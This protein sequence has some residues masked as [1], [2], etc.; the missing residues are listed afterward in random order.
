LGILK[1]RDLPIPNDVKE[2]L[3]NDGY[4]RL[5]PPQ[6]ESINAGVLE[7]SNLVLASPTASGKTLIAELCIIKN[8][9]EKGGK[10]VYLTPLKALASEK[11]DEFLKYGDLRRDGN[12]LRIVISTGDFDRSDEWLRNYDIIISTN[13]KIDS[14]FRHGVT[15]IN[16]IKTIVADETHLITEP[17]RG[18]TLEVILTKLKKVNPNAQILLLSATIRN[19][20]EMAE[21]IKANPITMNWRP[22]PLKEGVFYNNNIEFNDGSIKEIKAK[23]EDPILDII[24]DTIYN[25]GQALTFTETRRTAVKQGKNSSK[26]V[27][28]LLTQREKSMLSEIAERI[29]STG[30][31]TILSEELASQIKKGTS[32][33]HAGLGIGHR[34]IIEESFRKRKIKAL[35]ATPT[36]AAGVNLPARVV[37]ISSYSRYEPG[38]GRGQI[39]VLEYKQFSGRAGRPK[40]D[41]FGESVLIAKTEDEKE[42]LIE[43]YVKAKPERIES[44][45]AIE[46][47]LRPHILSTI[48]S[49]FVYTKKGLYDFFGETFYAYQND[50]ETIHQKMKSILDFLTEAEMVEIAGNYLNA[51]NFGRRV[52]ELYIDP[53]SAVIIREALYNRAKVLTELSFLHLLS[54]T[55]DIAPKLY[56]R[57][58]EEKELSIFAQNHL[59]EFM[60]DTPNTFYDYE[61]SYNEFLSELKCAA[62]LLEWINEKSEDEILSKYKVEPGDLARLVQNSEW[63]LYATHELA[64]LFGHKD[65]LNILFELRIR[66]KNGVKQELVHLVQLE[67]VGRIRARM[68][69]NSGFKSIDS[70][71]SADI[72]SLSKVPLI[73]KSIA[74]KI[75]EQLGGKIKDSEL[76]LIKENNKSDEQSLLT[77]FKD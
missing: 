19:A 43:N 60:T 28:D 51:T 54:H 17:D 69:F 33:H 62:V 5:Y 29:L 26:A 57:S 76:K 55:P 14:L 39:S 75:K 66:V 68:L 35:A 73:G 67:R 16:E 70:L 15:W 41:D 52:S 45:L 50:S 6:V 3:F 20:E 24:S 12:K 42:F 71:K 64:K 4:D 22:V 63:L 36:L 27:S 40:Y 10:A 65:L 53:L 25:G 1:V 2:I 31:K 77:E 34:K 58:K 38:L 11:Y 47:V 30:E 74:K 37:I 8:I 49:K 13:E 59:D 48:A 32:F 23:L 44:K 72:S 61:Y 18:P 9:L 56:T 21:W 7:G 46:K